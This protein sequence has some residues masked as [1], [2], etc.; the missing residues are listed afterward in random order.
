MW[1][2]LLGFL[3]IVALLLG[4]PASVEA[5]TSA[6]VTVTAVG[7]I[8]EAPGGFT[9]TYISDYEVGLNWTLGAGAENTMVRAAFGRMPEDR[10]DGYLVY[11]G[12]GT[13]TT[14]WVNM[15]TLSVPVYYRAWSENP[16]EVWE[17]TGST[18]QVEGISMILIALIVLAL[19]LLT[20]SFWQRKLWLFLATGLT[21]FGLGMYGLVIQDTDVGDILW[22]VGMVGIAMM[23]LSFLAP[24]WLRE[25]YEAPEA[26]SEEE[27]YEKELGE[28]VDKARKARQERKG[29][30][31]RQQ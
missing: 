17:E 2:V 27:A 11:Y 5:E 26:I 6:D 3:L 30:Y 28:M 19:G 9:V 31:P 16:S 18:G 10:T 4:S 20:T 13:G 21:W 22:I 8:C 12:D 7:Y 14:D 15:E 29:W 24:F 23:L 25:R 1:R